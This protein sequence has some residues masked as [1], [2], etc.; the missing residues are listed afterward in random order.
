MPWMFKFLGVEAKDW[1]YI[2]KWA[3]RMSARPAFKAVL[4]EGPKIGH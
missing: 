1:P 4:E 3:A 2:E